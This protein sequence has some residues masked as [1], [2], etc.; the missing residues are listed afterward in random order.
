MVKRHEASA[1]FCRL[2]R[3]LLRVLGRF[4][5][6][7]GVLLAGAVA[8]YTLLS[9][10]PMLILILIVL[11]HVVD[12]E[13]L[14]ATMS[15]FLE[16]AVPGYAAALTEQVRVFIQY[17]GLIG[18]VGILILLFFSSIAFSVLE[19]A[20]SFIFHRVRARRRHFLV[21]SVIPYLFI[22]LITLGVLTLSVIVGALEPL[23]TTKLVV[24]GR[25]LGLGIVFGIAVYALGLVAEVLL[26][27][28]FYLVLPVGPTTF[29]HALVGGLAATILWEI[30]RRIIVWYYRTYTF[31]NLIYG[32][33]A[34]V[35]VFLLGVEAV[36]LIVLLGAQVIAELEQVNE[37]I[38]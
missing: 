6:N 9:I 7:Q 28:A 32:S 8:F 10:I 30:T 26:I 29:R 24:F 37:K 19:N 1:T 20:I 25:K 36:A 35:V 22:L 2:A 11:S 14:I 16:L 34:S 33:F 3:F 4:R 21:S 38:R 31:V 5:Q 17:R 13:Q 18:T 27:T 12:P 23:E 15:T